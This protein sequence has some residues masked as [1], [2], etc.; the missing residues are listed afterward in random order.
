MY[1]R[2]LVLVG[3]SFGDR[4]VGDHQLWVQTQRFSVLQ[5]C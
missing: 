3:I 1:R 4:M 2:Y 5:P